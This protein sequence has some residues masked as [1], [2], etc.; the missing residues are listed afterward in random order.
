MGKSLANTGGALL[1]TADHGNAEVMY[2]EITQQVHTAHTC[3]QVP[4]LYL[5]VIGNS[6]ERQVA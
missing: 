4:L 1:I 2:D 5:G 6:L 3:Q